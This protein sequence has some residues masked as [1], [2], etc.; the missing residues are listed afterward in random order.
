MSQLRVLKT[1]KSDRIGANT[2][3][4]WGIFVPCLMDIKSYNLGQ[5]NTV[6]RRDLND[7]RKLYVINAQGYPYW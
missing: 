6:L 1:F 7:S 2:A 4:D 3:R 5:K